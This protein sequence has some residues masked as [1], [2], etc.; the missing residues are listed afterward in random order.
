MFRAFHEAVLRGK[1][2]PTWAEW[3]LAT[4]RV[5][6]GCLDSARQGGRRGRVPAARPGCG[7]RIRRLRPPGLRAGRPL[8]RP[9]ACRAD[10]PRTLAQH[11]RHGGAPRGTRC[12]P[13]VRPSQGGPG[14]SGRTARAG[15][16]GVAISF[17]CEEYVFSLPEIEDYIKHKLPV[18]SA[19][20]ET[21]EKP[22]PAV[23]PERH[24]STKHRPRQHDNKRSGGCNSQRSSGPRRVATSDANQ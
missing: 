19:A 10:R 12:R 6:H 9:E 11:R 23:K 22:L 8:A 20:D 21:L 16:S 7:P 3:A 4:Q 18:A 1:P 5:L 13:G 17:A 14:V 15:A 2:D 24:P